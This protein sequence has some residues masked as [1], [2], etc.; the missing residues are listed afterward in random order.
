LVRGSIKLSDD[1]S[2]LIALKGR[3]RGGLRIYVDGGLDLHGYWIDG[4]CKT[5][6]TPD[7]TTSNESEYLSIL[8]AVKDLA[9][10]VEVLI[11]SDS[12]LVVNQLNK[13]WETNNDQLRR[14]QYY[15][16]EIIFKKRLVVS[17]EWVP[18][19][20][21]KMGIELE[22]MKRVRD[23]RTAGQDGQGASG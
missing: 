22:G 12:K 1:L 20:D 16:R 17:Y 15:I 6:E 10:Q 9:P 23:R 2:D 4:L 7:G 18:R 5:K 11:L 14:L 19:S 3:E 13:V 21:N 8:L